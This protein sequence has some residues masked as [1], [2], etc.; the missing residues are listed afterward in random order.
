MYRV[1]SY[2]L[3]R[4]EHTCSVGAVFQAI[5]SDKLHN[6][7]YRN[8]S[9]S[10]GCWSCWSVLSSI[11]IIIKW[12]QRRR[13]PSLINSSWWCQ[14]QQVSHGCQLRH[15]PIMNVPRANILFTANLSRQTIPMAIMICQASFLFYVFCPAFHFIIFHCQKITNWNVWSSLK[16]FSSVHEIFV[17][18]EMRK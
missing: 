12:D 14:D 2:N 6:R 9:L 1:E 15:C 10:R 3:Q 8:C 13:R 7:N 5:S 18:T 4:C 17:V 16:L 11:T